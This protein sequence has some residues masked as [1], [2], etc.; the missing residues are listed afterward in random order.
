MPEVPD[1]V[2]LGDEV[3]GVLY[4]V[5][6]DT[7]L[8][9][10]TPPDW[11]PQEAIQHTGPLVVRYA[12]PYAYQNVAI[13]PGLFASDYGECLVGRVAWDYAQNNFTMHPRGTIAGLRTDGTDDEMLVR[14]LDFGRDVEVHAYRNL[15]ARM[16]MTQ[17]TGCWL[18]SNAPSDLPDLLT[19]HLPRLEHLPGQV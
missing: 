4:T 17:L 2:L 13:V 10:G 15:A 3:T 11:L 14:E 1:P 5:E 18:G 16:P 7:F 6:N 9:L 19:Q 8:I 12:L